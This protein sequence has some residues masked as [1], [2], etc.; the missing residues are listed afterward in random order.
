MAVLV[1]LSGKHQGKRLALPDGEVVIGRDVGCQ[2][3]LATE[4]VSRQHCRLRCHGDEIFVTDLG[5]RNGT[6]VNDMAIH[7]EMPMRPGDT[8]RVGPVAFELTGR[9]DAADP[10]TRKKMPSDDSILNWLTDE[11]DEA[12]ASDTT[13]IPRVAPAS[14]PAP[15]SSD[16]ITPLPP[17]QKKFKTIGEE[18]EDIIQRHF[19]LV[20]TGQL[21]KRISALKSQ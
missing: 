12:N 15:E 4:E 1:I 3:R 19:E 2:I 6:L 13:I 16:S 21:P 10:A 8:L 18:G 9:K 17:T 20:Q 11:D 5:S 14:K 7:G